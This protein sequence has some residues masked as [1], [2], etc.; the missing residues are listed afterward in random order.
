MNEWDAS[1]KNYTN[2]TVNILD[3]LNYF[4]IDSFSIFE[5]REKTNI[6]SLIEE[7]SVLAEVAKNKIKL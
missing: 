1:L 3:H 2:W 4:I 6:I 5:K 7:M